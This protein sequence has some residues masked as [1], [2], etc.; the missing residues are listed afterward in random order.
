[1][2]YKRYC[3]GSSHGGSFNT[4]GKFSTEHLETVLKRKKLLK[5]HPSENA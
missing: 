2:T 5:L 1:M 4:C 3:L